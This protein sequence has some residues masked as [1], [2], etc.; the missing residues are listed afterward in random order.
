MHTQYS[1]CAWLPQVSQVT[2]LL[3]KVF[4][5]LDSIKVALNLRDATSSCYWLQL[6]G[7]E[8]R[9][10]NEVSHY[11]HVWPIGSL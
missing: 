3:M 8:G 7:G 11:L 6:K 10:A 9:D 1:E 5:Y 4:S 2:T